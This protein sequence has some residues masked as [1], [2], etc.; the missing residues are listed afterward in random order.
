MKVRSNYW[1]FIFVVLVSF[2]CKKKLEK[3]SMEIE[4]PFY[5]EEM[6]TPE[7][8]ADDDPRYDDIHTIAD[9]SFINQL[10]DTV[11][12]DYFH[13][14]VYVANFFFTICPS[15]CPKMTA[16]LNRV[17]EAYKD[18]DRVKIISHT[19]MPWIDSVA[20]LKDYALAKNIDINQWQLVTGEKEEIYALARTSY[21]ADEGF[22]KTVTDVTDFLH[23]EKV[24]LI[25]Q[26][27]RIRGVYNG[28]ILLEMKRMVED[29]L[30][31]L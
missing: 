8:I 24:I 1:L 14:K 26:K 30:T 11:T 25:D 7:W 19:V 9:F 2:S 16:N 31:L 10:G 28:T 29:I 5:N 22:G 13:E 6:F 27:R 18:D 15:V 21:F 4:L 12:Q 3:K 17:Q 20:K 23:T